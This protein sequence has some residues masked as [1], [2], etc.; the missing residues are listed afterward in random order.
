MSLTP[1]PSNFAAYELDEKEVLRAKIL[2][3]EQRAVFQHRQTELAETIGEFQFQIS[4]VTGQ[5]VNLIDLG[6]LRGARSILLQLLQDDADARQQISEQSQQP[7]QT[8]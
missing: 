8:V 7:Q 6:Q 3:P 2:S 1:V 5:P 4:E